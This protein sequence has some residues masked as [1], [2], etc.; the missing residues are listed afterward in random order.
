MND[1]L[2]RGQGQNGVNFDFKV[3]FD[4]GGSIAPP[5]SRDLNQLTNAFCTFD[6]NMVILTWTGHELWRG[7]ARGSRTY[8]EAGTHRYTDRHRQLNTWRPRVITLAVQL[9]S[10]ND[11]NFQ[12]CHHICKSVNMFNSIQNG[13]YY[14]G[15]IL[16]ALCFLLVQILLIPDLNF[17]VFVQIMTWHRAGII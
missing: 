11:I 14:V 10:G 6:P 16:N 2:S 9:N 17:P 13:R 5:N 8:T 1:Y 3:Q 4:H 15:T 12:N 7:Q